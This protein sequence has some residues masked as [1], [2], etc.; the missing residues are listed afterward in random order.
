MITNDMCFIFA[1]FYHS[2][3]CMYSTV[4]VYGS[5]IALDELNGTAWQKAKVLT[6]AGQDLEIIWNAPTIQKVYLKNSLP[7]AGYPLLPFATFVNGATPVDVSSSSA[8]SSAASPSIPHHP[9]QAAFSDPDPTS[10]VPEVLDRGGDSDP[11]LLLCAW[12]WHRRMTPPSLSSLHVSSKNSPKQ[13]NELHSN[14]KT[15]NS[16]KA[17]KST[18]TSHNTPEDVLIATD[19]KCSLVKQLPESIRAIPGVR[20]DPIY[21]PSEAEDLGCVLSVECIP[22]R[23]YGSRTGLENFRGRLGRLLAGE[24]MEEEGEGGEVD[25]GFRAVVG[26]SSTAQSLVAVKAVTKDTAESIRRSMLPPPSSSPSLP[27]PPSSFP[28][29]LVS[30]PPFL[31]PPPPPFRIVTYNILADQYASTDKARTELFYYCPP[32]FLEADYRRQLVLAELVA[33]KADLILL[34]EVDSSA[35]TSYFEPLLRRHGYIGSYGNKAGKVREGCAMFVL[36]HRFRILDSKVIPLKDL[37]ASLSRA[38]LAASTPSS[39]SVPPAVLPRAVEPFKAMIGANPGLEHVLQKVGTIG[40][41]ALLEDRMALG[42]TLAIANTHLFFNP[43]APHVRTM[44]VYSILSELKA[45]VEGYDVKCRTRENGTI[46]TAIFFGGD[47]NSDL[48]DGIPGSLA[49]MKDGA[50]PADFW[51]WSFV[52]SFQWNM[53]TDGEGGEDSSVTP[54]T[55]TAVS[56]PFPPTSSAISPPSTT[57]CQGVSLTSPV[58]ILRSADDLKTPFS[59]HTD[60]YTELLDY[61]WFNDGQDLNCQ[62]RNES[63]SANSGSLNTLPSSSPCEPKIFP[64][65]HGGVEVVEVATMPTRDEV[66]GFLPNEHFP[67]DHLPIIADFKWT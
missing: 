32:P 54:S 33:Y 61:I 14:I 11:S 65:S 30:P 10:L 46:P 4:L 47:L 41:L 58:G 25:V 39:P 66:K 35:F 40:Q 27:P 34:Q 12:R 45:M 51:D 18:T 52:A 43:Q 63:H 31:G 42:R 6:V 26:V 2:C 24:R 55:P 56:P 22:F 5:P 19:D 21:T 59:N 1:L 8:A 62:G 60:T 15:S 20:L 49:L 37:F 44:H 67:S 16:S 13:A 64:T 38:K 36:S 48:K 3:C 9:F 28:S 50:L 17:S 57:L 23:L 7:L 53:A 29:D